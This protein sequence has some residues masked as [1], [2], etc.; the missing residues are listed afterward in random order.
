MDYLI[1]NR[2]DFFGCFHYDC[3]NVDMLSLSQSQVIIVSSVLPWCLCWRWRLALGTR[4]VWWI[5][6]IHVMGSH[7]MMDDH[8]KLPVIRWTKHA[9]YYVSPS[10]DASLSY[11]WWVFIIHYVFLKLVITFNTNTNKWLLILLWSTKHWDS[12]SI[13]TL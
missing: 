6:N 12:E 7:H 2:G 10:Y 4:N 11:V 1:V 8:H 9:S 3:C 13:S 5:P